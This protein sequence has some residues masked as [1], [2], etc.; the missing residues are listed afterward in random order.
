MR[1]AGAGAIVHAS[2]VR[3]AAGAPLRGRQAGGGL[4]GLRVSRGRIPTSPCQPPDAR[5][6]Q[7]KRDVPAR[8]QKVRVGDRTAEGR[9]GR[10]R[11]EA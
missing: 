11:P 10:A 5:C 1:P 3:P 9:V 6:Q 2:C 8:G 4:H 7:C